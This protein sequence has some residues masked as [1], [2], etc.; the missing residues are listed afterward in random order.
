[1]IWPAL[2]VDYRFSVLD[3][4]DMIGASRSAPRGWVNRRAKGFS[5]NRD[6][7]R[8]EVRCSGRHDPRYGIRCADEWPRCHRAGLQP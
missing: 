6:Q 4:M 5:K 3:A 2:A 1:M 7:R 8:A